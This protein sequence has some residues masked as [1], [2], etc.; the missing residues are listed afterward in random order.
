MTSQRVFLDSKPFPLEQG[1]QL[2]VV[3][4]FPCISLYRSRTLLLFLTS[5]FDSHAST[6][7]PSDGLLELQAEL[8]VLSDRLAH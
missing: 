7:K 6:V 1:W 5:P 4:L 8:P 2:E 3:E